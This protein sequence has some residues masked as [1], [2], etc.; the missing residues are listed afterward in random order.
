L[1]GCAPG[2][3]QLAR[4]YNSKIA[5]QVEKM[6]QKHQ[7]ITLVYADIYDFLY[8]MIANPKKYGKLIAIKI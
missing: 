2:H 4:I 7:N 3:N 1:R 8:D 5:K 6:K